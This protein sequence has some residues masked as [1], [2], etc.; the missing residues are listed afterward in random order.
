MVAGQF[1]PLGNCGV[2]V[3]EHE[4]IKFL[5][6]GKNVLYPIPI[7]MKV[8]TDVSDTV[9]L[10]G[11]RNFICQFF[12]NRIFQH[13]CVVTAVVDREYISIH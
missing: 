10:R 11:E 5:I 7:H 3:A 6:T 13:G 12:R 2:I 9:I 8:Q 4:N 1:N